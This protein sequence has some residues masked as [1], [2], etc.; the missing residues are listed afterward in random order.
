[1]QTENNSQPSVKDVRQQIRELIDHLAHI[2]PGQAPIKDFVHHNTLHGFQHLP[3]P[4]ALEAARKVTGIDGYLPENEFRKLYKQDRITRQDLLDVIRS[5]KNFADDE[6]VLTCQSKPITRAEIILTALINPITTVTGCQLTWQI[7][8]Q[9]ALTRFQPDVS[10]SSRKHFFSNMRQQV[11]SEASA[12]TELWSACLRVLDLQHFVLHPE[13][14]V[15]LDP[16]DAEKMLSDSLHE[17]IETGGEHVT[18]RMVLKEA[19]KLLSHTLGRVGPELTIRDVLHL[20]TGQDLL[21]EIRPALIRHLSAYLDQGMAAWHH[22][23]RQLGFYASWKQSA[24]QDMTWSLDNMSEI[25]DELNH[26]PNDAFE[27]VITE[28]KL[29]GIPEKHWPQYLER[30]A[31][32]LPGWSGMFL[33][34][35]QNPGYESLLP[36]H[37]DMMD[38][39]AVRLILE[40]L[41]ARRIC[42][43]QWSIG[44]RLDL[45]RWYFRQHPYQFMVRYIL[46]T[47]RL[48]EY[49]TSRAQSLVKQFNQEFDDDNQWQLLAQMIWT[50]RQSPA[51]DN[52]VGHS[53]FGSAWRL[54]RLA[55]HMGLPAEVIATCNKSQVE[56]ILNCL[57]AL[58]EG[59]R[60]F[61]WLQAYENH[62]RD[63]LF[64]A[65]VNNRGRGRW[66]S[67]EQRPQAQVVFCMDDREEGIRRHLEELNPAIETMGAAGFFGVAINWRGMDD[68]KI[69]PLCPVVVTPAH[70]IR[71]IPAAGEEQKKTAHDKRRQL[72]LKLSE[73]FYQET[74]RNL[75]TSSVLITSSAFVAMP[76]LLTKLFLPFTSGQISNWLLK[77]FDLNINSRIVINAQTNTE[78]SI[79]HPR[80]GF[81]DEEQADRVQ[82][83][84]RTIG[85]QQGLGSFVVMMGHGSISQNNPHLSAYDCGACSGRHGGPNARTF[86]A[87]ANR[88]EVRKILKDRGIDIPKDTWVM[89]AEH[90]TCDET[91]T[92]YD[93]DLI[94]DTLKP[95]FTKLQAELKQATKMSA[96]ERSRR[97][98]S[99]P[100]KLSPARALRHV[101]GRSTDFSQARPELGHATNAAAFIGRRS[102]SQG[103]FY[104]RRVFLISYDPTQDLEGKVLEAILLAAGPVGAGI[105]LEYYFSTVNNDKYGCG[106][107]VTHNVTGLFGVM[108]GTASDLRTGLPKQMIEIHEAMRLQIVVEASTEVLTTIYKRQAPLQEL[109]GNGWLL[110]NAIDPDSGEITMFKPEQGFVKWEG[111]VSNLPEVA[112]STNWY[113]G[114]QTPLTP[115]LIKQAEFANG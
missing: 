57:D 61:I 115:A 103:T 39:L 79:E 13:E 80:L 45:I 83:F 78:A 108:E 59:V 15:D 44:P 89:G 62:Y 21:E 87:M 69:T 106:S 50:W 12:I 99:A 10:E 74:R 16:D 91:I 112:S 105:N 53:V 29:I 6:P 70:E 73:V 55:Q 63:Q 102:I 20:L 36:E 23:Q 60:G 37:V 90:N 93:I 40:R 35:S 75:F 76:V 34:R 100:R 56:D 27:T 84:L 52:P 98:A 25:T 92:W 81:T 113:A 41:Y 51:S 97:F 4:A 14:L 109:V 42:R 24:L 8:E 19:E 107:K 30:L 26:L 88:P 33:W 43:D 65:L 72:R 71:E 96:H 7:E 114:H 3:F 18:R 104:D 11:S 17:T 66:A 64:N 5:D 54:F 28:L 2:L 22:P 9:H 94:P 49:L 86:A 68:E 111:E 32:E 82:N 48:P 85:L 38:Y 46:H 1:M 58:T 95:A 67:R 47:S 31:L 77:S 110:L 101:I